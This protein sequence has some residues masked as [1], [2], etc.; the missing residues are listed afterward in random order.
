MVDVLSDAVLIYT[1]AARMPQIK[2]EKAEAD[3]RNVPQSCREKWV[4]HE[5]GRVLPGKPEALGDY[6]QNVGKLTA[7][8]KA[9]EF[10]RREHD[11]GGGDGREY[12]I[13]HIFTDAADG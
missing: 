5:H 9:L 11:D 13:V 8:Y 2:P 4:I 7:I 6:D 10:H 12:R 3:F 1:D